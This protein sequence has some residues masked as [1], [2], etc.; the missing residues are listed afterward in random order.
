MD[1]SESH[2]TGL[3]YFGSDQKVNLSKH[4][5]VLKPLVHVTL[6]ERSM[7]LSLLANKKF[8]FLS[9]TFRI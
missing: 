8:T 6:S 1:P 9:Q 7:A 2:Q 5:S 3:A 4:G